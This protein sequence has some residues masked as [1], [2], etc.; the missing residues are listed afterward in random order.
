MEPGLHLTKSMCPTTSEEVAEMKKI[1]YLNAVGA[2]MYL[3]TT[4]RPDIAYT[5]GI[6]AR[7]N[8]NPGMAHWKAIKHVFRYLQGTK[9]KKLVYR[10][11]DSQ[12]L[13]TSFTDA[14]HGGCKDSGRS[15]G[16][17]L[18]KFGSGAVSWS[19]KLQPLVALSTTEA[20]YIAAVEA[21]KEIVWMRQLLAEFGFE[22]N[23]PSVLRIDNQSAISVSKNPEH[24]GRMKHLDLRFYWLRDQVTHGVI[25][26]L[27]VSTEV[28][29]ADL[30]TKPLAK[31]KVDRFRKMMGLED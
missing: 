29:P 1:P 5:V 27:F 14:D 9:D 23:K 28:M 18:I 4:T 21:G 2:L 12:E 24:H 26:P 30:L 17:Y 19:S 31:V 22:V 7:F 15:T 3:A 16:G 25:T 11:D 6:L 20:E 13:F 10:P 8:C